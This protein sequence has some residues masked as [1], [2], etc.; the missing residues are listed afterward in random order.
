MAT[1]TDGAA[2]TSAHRLAQLAVRAALLADLS[3]LWRAVD[4]TNLVGTI[5]VFAD[6][7]ALVVQTRHRESESLSRRYFTNFRTAEGVAGQTPLLPSIEPPT[8]AMAGGRI[9]G[10]GLAGIIRARRAGFA[11]GAAA[12][13]GFVKLSGTA[14]WLVLAGG[15]EL[16]DT[17]ISRDRRTLGWMRVTSGAACDWCARIAGQGPM[18][19]TRDAAGDS[20]HDH[21]GC[22]TEPVYS[23]ETRLPPDSERY[24]AVW[25]TSTEGLTGHEAVAAF[26][27]ALA[28]PSTVS[29]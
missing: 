9:R 29:P 8:A 16:I 28:E 25:E 2:L 17:A 20:F 3:T 6:I 1:T 4:P 21:D 24:R 5:G 11:P 10:A 15:R 14:G 18:Y 27:A 22:T 13:N 26:R 19:K 23:K 12:G 7:A